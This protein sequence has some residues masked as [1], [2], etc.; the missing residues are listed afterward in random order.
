MPTYGRYVHEPTRTDASGVE[1]L[2][3]PDYL[4]NQAAALAAGLLLGV[5]TWL[6]LHRR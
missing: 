4:P 2:S 1:H 5:A 3:V 6:L